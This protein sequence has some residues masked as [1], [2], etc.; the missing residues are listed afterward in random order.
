MLDSGDNVK[1]VVE[2]KHRFHRRDISLC[3]HCDDEEETPE[4]VFLHCPRFV[5]REGR[6]H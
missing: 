3:P 6:R 5:Q 2:V 1:A 4:H